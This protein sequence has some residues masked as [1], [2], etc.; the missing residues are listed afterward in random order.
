M[1]NQKNNAGGG[2]LH[3]FQRQWERIHNRSVEIGR[4]AGSIASSVNDIVIIVDKN[5]QILVDLETDLNALTFNDSIIDSIQHTLDQLLVNVKVLEQ[6]LMEKEEISIK[7]KMNKA[8]D[9]DYHVKIY[10]GKLRKELDAKM[11]IV[12]NDHVQRMRE[13][14]KE[15]ARKEEEKRKKEEELLRER[16]RTFS[17]AFQSEIDQYKKQGI[18][19]KPINNPV[20][21]SSSAVS[22]SEVVVQ[23]DEE[24][25][26]VLEK[27]L[28]DGE[29]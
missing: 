5:R 24:E 10:E 22:L 9:I 13:L 12:Q 23:V 16:Q 7:L 15:K 28:E 3:H 1:G 6:F 26:R 20:S 4:I 18:I 11:K 2:I 21:E 27:F 29:D 25:M 8:L 17:E 19:N 14:A